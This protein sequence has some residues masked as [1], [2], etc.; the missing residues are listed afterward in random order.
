MVDSGQEHGTLMMTQV[1]VETR[2][3]VQCQFSCFV[4]YGSGSEIWGVLSSGSGSGFRYNFD[5][6]IFL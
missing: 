4:S 5:V 1:R 3:V 6:Y 2:L